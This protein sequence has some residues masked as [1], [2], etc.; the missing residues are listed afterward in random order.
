MRASLL[1]LLAS[2]S[3]FRTP[4]VRNHATLQHRRCIAKLRAVAVQPEDK[5]PAE[6][7]PVTLS[8]FAQMI[9]EGIAIASLP[10][11]LTKLG[12]KPVEVG[13]ATSAFSL[14]QMV[15]CP[16]LVRSSG[17]VGRGRV[18]RWC[19][20]GA[21]LSNV[22]IA[23][24]P[25]VGAIVLFRGMGGAFAASAPVAQAAAADVVSPVQTP[26]ALSRVAAASQMAIVVGPM[27]S[28]V[29][30][31]GFGRLGV[32]GELR[33]RAVF[34]A[35]AVF[36]CGVLG[37]LATFDD[38]AALAAATARDRAAGKTKTV[39]EFAGAGDF[40]AQPLLR[41]VALVVGWS[42]TL[43]VFGYGLFAPEF[44]GYDQSR[45]SA[46]FSAGALTTIG[47]QL[48]FPRI[49]RRVGAHGTS[50]LGLL[51]LAA[52]MAGQTVARNQPFH[53]ALYLL[54]R[55]G[56]GVADTSTAT[57]VA[58]SSK[59]KDDRAR[60]LGLIQST[61]AAARIFTP[62]VSGSL[63]AASCGFATC[64]GSLPF[65]CNAGCA[66]LAAP[67]PFLLLRAERKAAARDADAFAVKKRE[68]S[69]PPGAQ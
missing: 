33:L 60:N 43:S 55:A 53:S 15:C 47:A 6:L 1:L 28:A 51:C 31:E 12:A 23:C 2:C 32:P 54:N 11:H 58:R 38:G 65:L 26:A 67:L 41:A 35:T 52:G 44:L 4:V 18:L 59:D 19:L 17:R 61:R 66:L 3:A 16:I 5:L 42:L 8:V 49:V 50:C 25:S 63:F 40:P 69:A 7:L 21:T 27:C 9:G 39:G 68:D 37:L 57:L 30:M 20:A 14:A 48:L 24:S 34:A 45:L 29:L 56:S 10:L 46:T 62:L 13:L 22:G 36:A 64:P